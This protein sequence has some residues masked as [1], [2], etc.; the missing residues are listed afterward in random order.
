M[1]SARGTTGCRPS[2]EARQLAETNKQFKA[3]AEREERE[4]RVQEKIAKRAKA[5][6]TAAATDVESSGGKKRSAPATDVDVSSPPHT[7]RKKVSSLCFSLPI[8]CFLP[9]ING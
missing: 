5:E 9:I 6:E 8:A 7:G 1:S 4:K 2:R 3:L